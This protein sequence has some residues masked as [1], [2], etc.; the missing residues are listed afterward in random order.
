M[1]QMVMDSPLCSWSQVLKEA[2]FNSEN[3][4]PIIQICTII[5]TKALHNRDV[6]GY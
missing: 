4:I 3:I 2:S 5:H 1:I 6:R